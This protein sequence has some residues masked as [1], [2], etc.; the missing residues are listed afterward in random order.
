VDSALPPTPYLGSVNRKWGISAANLNVP[1]SGLHVRHGAKLHHRLLKVEGLSSQFGE[2]RRGV[3][4]VSELRD[5]ESIGADLSKG[6]LEVDGQH[7]FAGL[8]VS[9]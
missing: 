3:A 1:V 2:N 4:Q 8:W 9:R 5:G 6:L 7:K